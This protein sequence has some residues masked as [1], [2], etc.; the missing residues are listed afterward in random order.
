M[1]NPYAIFAALSDQTNEGWV[2]FSNPPLLTHTIVKVRHPKTG[3]IVFPSRERSTPI[4]SRNTWL[5]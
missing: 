4:A 1:E 2:W 5:G 3:R